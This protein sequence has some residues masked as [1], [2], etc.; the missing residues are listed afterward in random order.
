MRVIIAGCGR[1]GAELAVRFSEEHEVTVVDRDARAFARL[2]PKFRGQ[3]LEGVGFDRDVLIRAGSSATDA[4]A[5]VTAGDNANIVI[6]RVARTVFRVPTVVAAGL[7]P[8]ARK[9]LP[10]ARAA[11]RLDDGLGRGADDPA[12]RTPRTQRDSLPRR[13]RGRTGGAGGP[14]SLGRTN[15]GQVSVAGEIKRD[16]HP[17]SRHGPPARTGARCSSAATGR[18]RGGAVGAARLEHLLGLR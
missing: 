8:P 6:A 11:D 12:D 4:L 14:R 15:R 16:G 13:G 9:D 18:D 10:P 17:A 5:A 7:R 3:T 2:G 1:M